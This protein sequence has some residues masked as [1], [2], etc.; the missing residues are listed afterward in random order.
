[1]IRI[2]LPNI[3]TLRQI[4]TYKPETG[5]LIYLD[6]PDD[7]FSN[8]RAANSWRTQFLGEIAGSFV[9]REGRTYCQVEILKKKYLA[10]RIIW[11]MYYGEEPPETID[12]IDGDGT[13]NRIPNLRQATS[14]Q[15]GWN[16][17]KNARNKSG[18]KGVSYNSEK[19][20]WRAAIC[21]NKK[22]ILL[23]YFL[24]P[25]AAFEAYTKASISYHGDFYKET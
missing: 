1:M 24:S 21:V 22:T 15:N 25:E 18:Y 23:G 7:M 16:S 6:R 13:N 2:V 4:L 9:T 10:H 20:K 17:R 12:H 11:K 14:Y 3:D 19:N 8:T 5:Q